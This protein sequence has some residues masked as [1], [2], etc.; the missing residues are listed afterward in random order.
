M[1][2]SREDLEREYR[3]ALKQIV[4]L[5]RDLLDREEVILR[6]KG[7][8]LMCVQELDF[9]LRRLRRTDEQHLTSHEVGRLPTPI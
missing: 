1:P 7:K 2:L 9:E 8:M 5:R 4:Q 3:S 6:M